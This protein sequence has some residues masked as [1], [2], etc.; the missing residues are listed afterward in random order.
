[1]L[2][3]K[4]QMSC[5]DQLLKFIKINIKLYREPQFLV[6]PRFPNCV[7]QSPSSSSVSPSTATLTKKISSMFHHIQVIAYIRHNKLNI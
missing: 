7:G 6:P 2:S 4:I 3:T 5:L 1:M